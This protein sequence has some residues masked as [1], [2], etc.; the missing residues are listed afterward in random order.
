MFSN[1]DKKKKSYSYIEDH[2]NS[3]FPDNN[4]KFLP[5]IRGLMIDFFNKDFIISSGISSLGIKAS[6]IFN[7]PYIIFDPTDNSLSEWN[8][9]YF[10]AKLKPKFANNLEEVNKIIKQS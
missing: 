7:I 3:N 1:L 6:E 2:I 10:N 4:F 8:N 9:I 5:P